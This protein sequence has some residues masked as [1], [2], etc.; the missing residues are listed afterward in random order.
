MSVSLL[1]NRDNSK[2]TLGTRIISG[3]PLEIFTV[4]GRSVFIVS[5]TSF[6]YKYM[7]ARYDYD[8]LPSMTLNI[9]ILFLLQFFKH[10]TYLSIHG[11]RDTSSA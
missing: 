8:I 11:D 9:T 6:N 5:E 7:D 2:S 4:Q 3:A 10:M 1:C